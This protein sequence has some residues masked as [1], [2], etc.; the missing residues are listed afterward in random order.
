MLIRVLIN[1]HGSLS[2]G[3][4]KGSTT[5]QWYCATAV[6]ESSNLCCRN[7]MEHCS[8]WTAL[9]QALLWGV[10]HLLLSH[11]LTVTE[12]SCCGASADSC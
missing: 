9:P 3:L 5:S 12:S 6:K 8:L 7:R 4:I 10:A 11:F 2:F 1:M